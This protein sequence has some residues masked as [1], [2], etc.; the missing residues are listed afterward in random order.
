MAKF[1]LVDAKNF[2]L[3]LIFPRHCLGCK[4][5]LSA[6]KTT[7]PK[8]RCGGRV[9]HLCETCF[10]AI[11]INP[12]T[13]CFICSK[14]TAEGLNC[15]YCRSKTNLKRFFSAG[16]YED[17]VLR[18]TVHY[19]KYNSLESLA[20][21][22]GEIAVKFLR[23]NCLENILKK[24]VLVPVPLTRRRFAKRGFNQAELI[25]K[26]LCLQFNFPPYQIRTDLIKRV[27]FTKPQADIKDFEARKLNTKG[28]FIAKKPKQIK[29]LAQENYNLIIF[30]DVSTSGATLEECARVLKDAGAKEI[31]G[32][33]I[34]RG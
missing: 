19:L 17:P 9:S 34:A 22:L 3:D 28:A 5:E 21:A 11:R 4:K 31:W 15:S 30:D 6:Q 32:F 24:S 2:I 18:E 8:F 20:E 14:R 26:A 33:V 1:T 29:Q 13:Q 27:S 25:A 23:Q 16:R 7:T 12:F 10:N